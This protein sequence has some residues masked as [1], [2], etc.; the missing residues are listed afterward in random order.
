MGAKVLIFADS[1]FA[2]K[3]VKSQDFGDMVFL[4][5]KILP[6][7]SYRAL[8]VLINHLRPNRPQTGNTCSIFNPFLIFYLILSDQPVAPCLKSPLKTHEVQSSQKYA[9]SGRES[10]VV[11][12]FGN[13]KF[14]ICLTSSLRL[15]TFSL[16][17]FVFQ[18][19]PD[20]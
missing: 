11:P 20:I 4:F 5:I 1:K 2:S 15:K 14:F 12:H 13:S 7:H 9:I 10:G 18:N 16:G 3:K 6:S 8:P 17:A 19:K